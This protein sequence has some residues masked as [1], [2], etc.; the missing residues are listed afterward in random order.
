MY[1]AKAG[2]PT[3]VAHHFG[4]RAAPL[5]PSLS[6]VPGFDAACPVNSR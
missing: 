4:S 6:P 2:F 5:G 3:G 1:Y